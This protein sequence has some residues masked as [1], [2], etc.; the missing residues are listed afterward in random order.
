M[1][2]SIWTPLSPLTANIN[3]A[4]GSA[5]PQQQ[6]LL[7]LC[8]V[9]PQPF[10]DAE[11]AAMAP[12]IQVQDATPVLMVMLPKSHYKSDWIHAGASAAYESLRTLSC[13][14]LCVLMH[15]NVYTQV[16]LHSLVCLVQCCYASVACCSILHNS[17]AVS[18]AT[19][20]HVHQA[21]IW[22]P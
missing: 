18:I 4:M 9:L 20:G 14:L 2:S 8:C 3:S 16:Y 21:F 7:R 12:A 5:E 10:Q 11:A 6:R 19:E 1:G 15:S 13:L 22:R 17:K